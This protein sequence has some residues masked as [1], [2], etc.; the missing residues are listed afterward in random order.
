QGM[1]VE[2]ARA[3]EVLAGVRR[4]ASAQERAERLWHDMRA[5]PVMAR[6]G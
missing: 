1:R 2:L 5:E 4:D 3:C 6:M